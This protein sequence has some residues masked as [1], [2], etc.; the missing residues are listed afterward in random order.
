MRA[1]RRASRHRTSPCVALQRLARTRVGALL[2]PALLLCS[3]PVC[4]SSQ[5]PAANRLLAPDE[6]V[7][8][9]QRAITPTTSAAR[10][11]VSG[12]T[13]P[14]GASAAQAFATARAQHARMVGARSALLAA[15]P[16]L[17]AFGA[18]W[19]PLGPSAIQS[20]RFGTV[21]GR[22]TSIAVD[23]GDLSGNTV[24]LGSSG[25]GVWKS[26]NAAGPAASVSFQP[27]TDTLPVFSANAGNAATPSL[28][29]GA[30]AAQPGGLVLAGTGD[31]NDSSDSYYGGGILRSADG[32]VTWTLIPGSRDGVYGNHSFVGL[33]VAGFAW[34]STSPSLIVAAV[35]QSAEGVLVNA[36]DAQASVMGLYFSVDAGVTWRM[37]TVQDGSQIVQQ[38]APAGGNRGGHAA[39]S[40][41]WNPV[42]Q[43]FY[44]ALRYHGYYE[45][46]DG[47]T[48]TRLSAQPGAGL[49]T[50]ACPVAPGLPGSTL[51]PIFRGALAVDPVS[52]DTFALTVDAH[53]HDTGLFR[54]ACNRGNGS[55]CQTAQPVFA[56]QLPGAALESTDGSGT[57]AQGDYNLAVAAVPFAGDTLLFVGT[58]DL[59]RCSVAAGCALRNTTNSDNGCN[60]PAHV[61]AAQHAIASA[62]TGS[63]PVLFVGNDSGLWRSKD[64]VNQQASVCSQDDAA[65]FQNLNAALGSLADVVSFAQDPDA[66][67]V[68][69]AGLGEGGTA[70]TG[71]SGWQQ[72]STGEGGSVAIDPVDPTLWF[73]SSAA[74]ISVDLCTGGA[75]CSAA[76][77]ALPPAIGPASVSNDNAR[78]DAPWLLDPSDP[79]QLIAGTCRVWRGPA[80]GGTAW[81]A[82]NALSP[83]LSGPQNVA[84]NITENGLIRSLAAAPPFPAGSGLPIVYAGMSGALSGGGNV[85]GHIFTNRGAAP[86]SGT[87]WVDLA[88]NPVTNNIADSYRFNSSGFDVSSLTVDA[89]DPTGS[90]V[91]AT[92]MGFSSAGVP[93]PHLYRST[94]GG[95]HWLDISSNLPNVPANSVAVDPNDANTLY[96]A[97]DTGVYATSTVS[98]CAAANCWTV[99]GSGLPNAPAM[100]LATAV[101]LATGDG[102][103]G[104]LRVATEGR[105]LWQVPLLTAHTDVLPAVT[106][107]AAALTFPAQPANTLSAA[108]SLTVTNTGNAPL[109]VSSVA[110]AG[111]FQ[112]TTNCTGGSLAVG[113]SCVVQVLFLPSAAGSRTGVLTLFS[114]IAGGQTT[115]ALTGMATPA[116]SVVLSPVSLLFPLTT[117]GA[118]S[119]VQNIL[120]ANTGTAASTI[121]TPAVIGDFAI[122]AN[123]CGASLAANTGCAVSVVFAPKASGSR[124]GLFRVT[125]GAGTLTATL[126]GPAVAPPTDA[127]SATSLSFGAQAIGFSSTAQTLILTNSG[128]AALTL[129]Q[130]TVSAGDFLVVNGC[131]NSLAGHAA[132]SIS[133]FFAPSRLGSQSGTLVVS[134]AY[135]SQ[136][137]PLSGLG[138]APPGVSLSPTHSLTFGPTAV[139]TSATQTVTLTNNGGGALA[140]SGI[141]LTGDFSPGAGSTCAGSLAAGS[142]C[143]LNVVFTPSATGLRYGTLTVTDDSPTS[144]HILALTGSGLNFSVDADGV[145]SATIHS[146]ETAAFPLLIS[147]DAGTPGSATVACTGLP[148][149][150]TCVVSPA[151]VPLTTGGSTLV[152]ATVQTG[153]QGS[154]HLGV[155]SLA[156]PLRGAAWFA[157]LLPCALFWPAAR[158]RLLRAP[159]LLGLALVFCGISGCSM[160]R[161]IPPASAGGGGSAANAVSTPP[162]TY[163]VAVTVSSAGLSRELDFTLIV[164]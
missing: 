88:G 60:A 5:Q 90:T 77:G 121:G 40:V 65:H 38:P 113:S 152:V 66:P 82:S 43:R 108:Q 51:C 56:V 35:S 41:V 74:G 21:S 125:T 29:I 12:R 132:C 26:T 157:S 36:P 19:Q 96:V 3:A 85:A 107:S 124:S 55:T 162:G 37:A 140:I 149:N 18:A 10:S 127:I 61:G 109:S 57:I 67:G 14:G 33:G 59:F 131:G 28:S 89:H 87:P 119:A 71:G 128:D 86:G 159:M 95:G 20:T 73:F 53:N 118:S 32:G 117:V 114:N 7:L 9:D 151:T 6:H 94:D 106:L 17:Q 84:C 154:A 27:L 54:D 112:A 143:A 8:R 83:L 1:T 15:H 123:T 104:E 62:A 129:I 146:G 91:Y 138:I 46:A 100:Q 122:A 155:P 39:T 25:G 137:I 163:T 150:S 79:A 158:R 13:L 110:A 50:S 24:Y 68:L 115:A 136:T 75:A 156:R 161:T 76:D 97:M 11:G 116:P 78:L 142:A 80:R 22:I 42:R 99:Y 58:H 134:D 92:V 111:D 70:S 144:P 81:S 4:L 93:V 130:A 103:R 105:G 120:I 49:S 153:V 69:L 141:T 48:W 133:V 44:A 45:S 16:E 145:T 102:R 63:P 47:Q 34:S 160:G 135:R 2:L 72:I 30:L 126:S 101:N 148:A 98:T 147:A 164:Q 31:P 52:G 64:L 139:H 23:P